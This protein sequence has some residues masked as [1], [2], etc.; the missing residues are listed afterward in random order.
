MNQFTVKTYYVWIAILTTVA[1][2]VQFVIPFPY[3]MF[4]AI[5]FFIG[6]PVYFRYF[7][8]NRHNKAG[9]FGGLEDTK[10]HMYCITCG[11]RTNERQCS[12]C[13]G[14]QFKPR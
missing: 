7:V 4:V 6:M 13:G 3:D 8:W 14:K 1:L 10:L 5:G 2:A 9:M 12:R 11:K